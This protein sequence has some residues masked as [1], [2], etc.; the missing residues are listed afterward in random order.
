MQGAC[1]PSTLGLGQFDHCIT[2]LAFMQYFFTIALPS[3]RKQ[4]HQQAN[5]EN[6][7]SQCCNV[8]L[9]DYNFHHN[10]NYFK[11]RIVL[12]TAINVKNFYVYP[13]SR[14]FSP[15]LRSNQTPDTERSR[16]VPEENYSTGNNADIDKN[17]YKMASQQLDGGSNFFFL[18]NCIKRLVQG[19][20]FQN[21]L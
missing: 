19:M 3:L 17:F 20:Y 12:P 4:E 21:F 18:L 7:V 16:G 1:R 15:S 14:P 8:A 11:F 2:K 9:G 13:Q 10:S 5:G 6:Q